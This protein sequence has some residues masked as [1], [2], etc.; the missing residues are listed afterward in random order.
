V[1]E[2]PA[3]KELAVAVGPLR[4]KEPVVAPKSEMAAPAEAVPWLHLKALAE[5]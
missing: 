4:P 1:G 3:R 5:A 2:L